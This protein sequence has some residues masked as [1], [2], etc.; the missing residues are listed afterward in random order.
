MATT[1]EIINLIA[2]TIAADS[3][4]AEWC[5]A[6]YGT[7][8]SIYVGID[9]KNPA[10]VTMYPVVAIVDV[11][12]ARGDRPHDAWDVT[13]G[14]GVTQEV[15]DAADGPPRRVVYRGVHEAERLR[16]LVEDALRRG[17][18]ARIDFSGESAAMT[19]YPTFV[20]FTT[21]TLSMV[22]VNRRLAT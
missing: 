15:I 2:D 8:G 4:L 14:C 17:R 10:P 19:D 9:Q 12:Q 21:A 7:R 13:I 6:T 3:A 20:S 18:F 16:E 5:L 11:S 22:K 1:T